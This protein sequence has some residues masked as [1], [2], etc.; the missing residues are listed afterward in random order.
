[1]D[2]SHA[3]HWPDL[4][5]DVQ[6]FECARREYGRSY[7]RVEPTEVSQRRMLVVDVGNLPD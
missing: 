3:N 5:A 6:I 2:D 4:I 1:M 7:I